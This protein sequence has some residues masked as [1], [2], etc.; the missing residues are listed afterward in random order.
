MGAEGVYWRGEETIDWD[1]VFAELPAA[2]SVQV[3]EFVARAADELE[4]L[5]I[6]PELVAKVGQ[7]GCRLEGVRYFTKLYSGDEATTAEERVKSVLVGS[8]AHAQLELAGTAYG[9]LTADTDIEAVRGALVASLQQAIGNERWHGSRVRL[10]RLEAAART[11]G[12]PRTQNVLGALLTSL[13]MRYGNQ[14]D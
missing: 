3:G 5:H 12:M 2:E 9:L 6:S 8:I 7:A 13:A 4:P 11:L 14:V 1:G 10:A